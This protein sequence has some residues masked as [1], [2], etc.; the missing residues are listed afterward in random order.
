MRRE[1]GRKEGV[2]NVKTISNSF[3][4]SFLFSSILLAKNKKKKKGY[5]TGPKPLKKFLKKL[6]TKEQKEGLSNLFLIQAI[7]KKRGIKPRTLDTNPLQE[8]PT[9]DGLKCY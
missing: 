6:E 9:F 3:S 2:T 8:K 7:L 1:E 5:Q 4:F